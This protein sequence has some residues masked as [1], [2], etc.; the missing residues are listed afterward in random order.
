M[1]L[2]NILVQRSVGHLTRVAA[3]LALLALAIMA[4]SVIYPRPL[5]VVFAMSVGHVIGGAAFACYLVAVLVD[6][7]RNNPKAD[8]IVP[9]TER[10]ASPRSERP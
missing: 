1:K 7:S 3:A 6:V 2:W 10:A 8:S 5:L 9:G 4:G